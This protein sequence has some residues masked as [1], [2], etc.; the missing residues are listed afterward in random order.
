MRV[1]SPIPTV[2]YV[3][4][5]SAPA[6][7]GGSS[8]AGLALCDVCRSCHFPGNTFAAWWLRPW[9]NL[10][11]FLAT[12]VAVSAVKYCFLPPVHTMAYQDCAASAG[13]VVLVLA[14]GSL[15]VLGDP[16]P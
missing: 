9:A 13:H 5:L 14:A 3:V 16:P 1:L 8:H 7:S 11:F 10:F 12:V 15:A 6:S 4:A 2:R